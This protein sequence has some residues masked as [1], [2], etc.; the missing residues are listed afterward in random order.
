MHKGDIVTKIAVASLPF[1]RPNSLINLSTTANKHHHFSLRE[2]YLCIVFVF[3]VFLPL[4]CMCVSK[5]R[6]GE[7]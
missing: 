2:T 1:Q 5:S 4:Y 3:Y 6:K 7:K